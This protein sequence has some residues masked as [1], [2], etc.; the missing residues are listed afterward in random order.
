MP[1]IIITAKVEDA[2]VWEKE[3]RTHGDLFK[4]QTCASPVE[5]AINE[6]NEVAVGFDVSDMEAYMKLLETEG[7]EAMGNDGVIR[8]SVKIFVM[9]K[10]FRF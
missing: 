5:I 9:D 4:R 10:E 8:E 2:K 3:F 7:P 1:R 6:G